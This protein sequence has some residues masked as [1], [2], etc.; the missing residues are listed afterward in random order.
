MTGPRP[1][2]PLLDGAGHLHPVHQQGGGI[3]KLF[4]AFKPEECIKG[5][6]PTRK[7]G[8]LTVP[9]AVPPP[10]LATAPLAVS[11]S[12]TGTEPLCPRGSVGA[13][14]T[15]GETAAATL[16]QGGGLAPRRLLISDEELGQ[17]AAGKTQVLGWRPGQPGSLWARPL[18]ALAHARAHGHGHLRVQTCA[19]VPHL[20]ILT[21]TCVYTYMHA[22]SCTHYP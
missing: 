12:T 13:G 15:E 10:A 8:P 5:E 11:L 22:C 17:V 9:L 2:G 21:G 1:P 4:S 20:H 3:S 18:M 6:C 14:E 19:C 16:R 7:E